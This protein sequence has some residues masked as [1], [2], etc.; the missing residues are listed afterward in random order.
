M[1][2]LN[3]VLTIIAVFILI[4]V[5]A[6]FTIDYLQYREN[7]Y[8][9]ISSA[10]ADI[11][12]LNKSLSK[13]SDAIR[14]DNLSNQTK[15]N[16]FDNS[17]K[18]Y[19]TFN[20]LND[21][22]LYDNNGS[23][24]NRNLKLN[25]PLE[26]NHGMRINTVQNSQGVNNLLICDDKENCVSLNVNSDG[27]NI[28][29]NKVSSMSIKS[30]SNNTI[31]KFDMKNNE[32]FI[33]G[34]DKRSP[35]FIQNND[36]YI[37]NK[38]FDKMY[39]QM[40]DEL[41]NLKNDIDHVSDVMQPQIDGLYHF[42]RN[43]EYDQLLNKPL[44]FDGKFSSLTEV[45][46]LF[47]GNYNSLNDKPLLFNGDYNLLNNKPILFDGN[48]NSLSGKPALFNGDYNLLNNKPTIFNGNYNSLTNKPSL[49]DGNYNTLTNKP[50]LFDGNYNTL[51]NKPALFNGNYNSLTDKPVL[52]NGDYNL[53]NNKPAL[54]NGNYDSLTNKPTLFDGNYDSLTNKPSWTNVI[55]ASGMMY[56]F[57]SIGSLRSQPNNIWFYN[58]GS[59]NT[60]LRIKGS[61]LILNVSNSDFATPDIYVEF[62]TNI[63]GLVQLEASDIGTTI[64][65]IVA[66][67]TINNAN[68][69]L[70]NAV[71]IGKPN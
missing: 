42:T 63:N 30:Q 66:E 45:P 62:S 52:F 1:E 17:L 2:I 46:I 14:Y 65:T 36:V 31:A 16:N 24:I 41:A 48:Y 10:N 22:K 11:D 21:A 58:F 8:S 68:S 71:K 64:W 33:G 57:G 20:N 3:I 60:N 54:F 70:F 23:N 55:N 35:L 40:N 69:I 43:I 7:V 6:Y 59:T 37:Q 12:G 61:S 29:P 18:D 67:K 38:S 4:G 19:F 9:A 56:Q 51:T 32:I 49:F 53:L 50:S 47:D 44:L 39:S 15:F 28:I 27:F 5:S 26:T 25:T 13:T 34:S